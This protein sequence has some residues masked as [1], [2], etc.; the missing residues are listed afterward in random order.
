MHLL[1]NHQHTSRQF[2]QWST[3]TIHSITVVKSLL[4]THWRSYEV[5]CNQMISSLWYWSLIWSDGQQSLVLVT[6]LIRWSAVFGTGHLFDQMVSSLWYWS[7]IWSDGQQSLVLVTY[8]TACSVARG[9]RAGAA[10]FSDETWV[11][12]MVFH[13]N[14]FWQLFVLLRKNVLTNGRQTMRKINKRF[15]HLV[16]SSG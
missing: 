4:A 6:Y 9:W 15:R 11:W 12:S 16:S 3:G 2:T 1:V 7:L 13:R 14:F 10:V 5:S 8:L